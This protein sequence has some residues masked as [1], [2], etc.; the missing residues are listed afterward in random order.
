MIFFIFIHLKNQIEIKKIIR[1][2]QYIYIYINKIYN[3]LEGN[4]NS[5]KPINHT[6]L[7]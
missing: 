3:Y 5:R 6:K 7:K 2:T 1:T 4:E